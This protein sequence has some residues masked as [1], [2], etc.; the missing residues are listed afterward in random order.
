MNGKN[1]IKAEKEVNQI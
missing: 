1:D